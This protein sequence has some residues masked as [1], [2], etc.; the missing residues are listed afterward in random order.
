MRHL[1]LLLVLAGCESGLATVVHVD[2]AEP[3]A[4][5][6][7]ADAPG[8]LVTDAG[9]LATP[10]AALCGAPLDEEVIFSHDHGFGC[11][12]ERKGTEEVLRAWI[13]PAPEEWDLAAF[14]ALQ[15][16]A[17][18]GLT[19]GP[20]ITGA[21][22]S[23]DTADTATPADTSAETGGTPGLVPEPDPTW[24]QA[25]VRAT[26]KRDVTPCGGLLRG[27]IRIE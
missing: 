5:A 10:L 24:P 15:P 23:G 19:L 7:S 16:H 14:C 25:E 9:G 27:D 22:E 13:Q 6:R 1:P 8:V 26:W 3:V 12:D 18:A 2:V 11:L 21:A 20:D 17:Y 4:T